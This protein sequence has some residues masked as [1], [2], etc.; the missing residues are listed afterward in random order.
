MEWFIIIFIAS[1]VLY[2][3]R[4]I[5]K[6]RTRASPGS[7]YHRGVAPNYYLISLVD[8]VAVFLGVAM[9]RLGNGRSERWFL[10]SFSI[11]G[12]F[13]RIFYTDN[14]FVLLT[15]GE[16]FRIT[17]IDQLVEANI[18]ITVDVLILDDISQLQIQFKW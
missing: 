6:R 10:N 7:I 2:V 13:Y 1:L 14:L 4:R 5:V 17:S 11:F 15:T 8:S 9:E 16:Q 12:M 3:M 18:P